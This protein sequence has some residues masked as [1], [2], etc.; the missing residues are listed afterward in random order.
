MSADG[1]EAYTVLKDRDGAFLR[2]AVTQEE[3]EAARR[4][5]NKVV[6]GPLNAAWRQEPPPD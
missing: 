2:Y 5:P 3:I 1:T 4:D 6:L